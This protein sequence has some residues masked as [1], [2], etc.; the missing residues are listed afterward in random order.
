MVPIQSA[1]VI[2]LGLYWLPPAATVADGGEEP[3]SH[4]MKVVVVAGDNADGS[5]E[6]KIVKW[7]AAAGA[8][9]NVTADGEEVVIVEA[10]AEADGRQ[11][12]VIRLRTS[13]A[14]DIQPGGPWLG[15]Q[16]GP[17][18]RALSAQMN[19]PAD[20]GQMILNV[21]EGSPADLAGFQQYDVITA[22]NGQPT[23][24]DMTAFL[25]VVRSFNPNETHAFT[26]LRAGQQ[27]QA[28]VTVVPRPA[29][30]AMPKMKYE[31]E[32]VELSRDRMFGR[33]GMVEKDDQGNWVFKGFDTQ[34]MP[35]FFKALPGVSDLDFNIALPGGPDGNRVFRHK[36]EA[37]DLRISID[38]TGQVTVTRSVTENGKTETT[39]STYANMEEF[40]AQEPALHDK[41]HAGK[42]FK[43]RYLGS[44]HGAGGWKQ[45][46]TQ[47]DEQL[48]AEL[49]DH[50]RLLETLQ[51]HNPGQMPRI[52]I[53]QGRPSTRFEV[54][55]EG[56]IKVTTRSGEDELVETFNNVEE[57]ESQRPDLFQRYQRFQERASQPE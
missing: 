27:V 44:P 2:L 24:G 32:I 10:G 20:S 26:L 47:M 3:T 19:L 22:I 1:L 28:N 53:L 16:F 41:F 43:F 39:T 30:D 46:Y 23:P 38:E 54:T 11:R 42:D 52:S 4:N 13:A 50:Q 29:P 9:A 56:Q 37:E 34:N 40:K 36:T 17:V 7:H 35:D 49:A 6:P 48:R 5:G 25:E 31:S 18:P 14:G 12:Q 51:L 8:G 21:A 57:M 45:F 33:G 15:V 55:P